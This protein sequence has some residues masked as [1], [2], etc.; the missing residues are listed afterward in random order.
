MNE[1]V[2]VVIA[3]YLDSGSQYLKARIVYS[4]DG[5]APTLCT[6]NIGIGITKVDVTEDD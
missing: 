3:G 2:D 4:P 5:I 1:D 6:T